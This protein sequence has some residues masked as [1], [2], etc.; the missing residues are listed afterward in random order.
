MTETTTEKSKLTKLESTIE[1]ETTKEKSKSTKFES[2]I[3]DETTTEI[4]KSTNLESTQKERTTSGK[5]ISISTMLETKSTTKGAEI[6]VEYV[7]STIPKTETTTKKS[8][9]SLCSYKIT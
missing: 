1:D 6:T 9:L 2:T 7:K 8:V 4:S 5:L 3:E